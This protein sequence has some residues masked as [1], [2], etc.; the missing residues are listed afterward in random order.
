MTTTN[1]HGSPL[2]SA[3]RYAD[4]GWHVFPCKPDKRP[5]TEHGFKEATRDHARID[6][7]WR[8]WPD[9]QVGVACGASG[10]A[11]IDLDLKPSENKDGIAAFARLCDDRGAHGCSLIASTPRGGRHYVYA[12]PSPPV[13][14]AIDVIP[15][16]GIDVRADGGYIVVP[17]P[18][19]PG[20][21]WVLGDPFE[22][23][24]EDGASCSHIE[25]MPEWVRT[26]ASTP[27]PKAREAGADSGAVIPLDARQV[28][29][30][31][32]AL[33]WVCN[34]DRD[35]W[36]RVGMALKSTGARAQAFEL[37]CEWSSTTEHSKLWPTD[38][39]HAEHPKFDP[40]D[41]AYQ[42]DSLVEFFP[43]GSEVTI[44]TLFHMARE[45][46]WPG[47]PVPAKPAEPAPQGAQPKPKSVADRDQPFPTHLLDCPGL[48]G[49]VVHWILDTSP[50]KQPALCLASTLVTL[51][52]VLGRRVC[53]PT[54]LRTNIYAL[55]IG[56]TG[57]GKDPSI[58]RP[59]TLLAHSMLERFVGPGE[60]KSDSGLR[61]ALISEPSHACLID[62]FIKVLRNLSGDRVPPHLAG[63]KRY[64]LE[65]FSRA[66]SVH[67]AAAYA[68][69]KQNA[70]IAINEPNFGIY[71]VGVPSD[72]FDA[73][74]R[75]AVQDGFLNRFLCF[76]VDDSLPQR[77]LIDAV[78]VPPAHLVERLR[79]LDDR[80]SITKEG[81]PRRN[82]AGATSGIATATCCRIVPMIED[83]R[84][85][86]TELEAENDERIR[87]MQK[88]GNPLANLWNRFSEH[89][90]KLAL[91]RVACE[92]RERAISQADV[93]W[94]SELVLW[95]LTRTNRL[96]EAHVA[97]SRTEA[98]TKRVLRIV[99]A[100]GAKGMSGS[101]LA[102]RT[103]WLRRHDRKDIL[104]TLTDSRQIR[105]EQSGTPQSPRT[106]YFAEDA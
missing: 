48:V 21:E 95:C 22:R 40:R 104:Q 31:R 7:W 17:S 4:A 62:E 29:E 98:E 38:T 61:A 15:G 101:L 93:K 23:W 103:Q 18:A 25:P 33:A 78:L 5:Y 90:Q 13:G 89:V 57:C 51:G 36:L 77:H 99:A 8:R 11:A 63:I 12:M 80:L 37:W 81:E 105:A 14:C 83:A 10:I 97:D 41:Q 74:D 82:L 16:S 67:L 87:G 94:A 54:N 2:D 50:Q 52:A 56:E 34:D 68:D 76:F 66:G 27:Q 44:A 47:M 35:V 9:A 1:N 71:G 45:N 72:L 3:L 42:W 96:A 69:R 49:D 30:I 28:A 19:S 20:R 24:E 85:E 91:I 88:D 75:G 86:V 39:D 43:D 73:L 65:L 106:T 64:I 84:T 79:K 70:P 58:S 46:D 59:V 100:A 102:R 55:G 6:H 60:W 92:D 26:L 53:T 32:S